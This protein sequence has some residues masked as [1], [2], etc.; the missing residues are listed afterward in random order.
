M[1]EGLSY[2]K[3]N[4]GSRCRYKEKKGGGKHGVVY[5]TMYLKGVDK[6]SKTHN[7]IEMSKG[8]RKEG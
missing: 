8:G 2:G 5:C 4:G 3:G 1:E 7:G 6:E